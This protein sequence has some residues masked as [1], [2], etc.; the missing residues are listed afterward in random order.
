MW[1]EFRQ[2]CSLSMADDFRVLSTAR[3]TRVCLRVE[4]LQN[5]PRPATVRPARFARPEFRPRLQL[6][7]S[8]SARPERPNCASKIS[9]PRSASFLP[10]F[11]S[12]NSFVILP[13]GIPL[14]C[15][16]RSS[17]R[18]SR[19]EILPPAQ[20]DLSPLVASSPLLFSRRL[21]AA[22]PKFYFD[23][24]GLTCFIIL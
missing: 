9:F 4:V 24:I 13:R 14:R 11:S 6:W 5:S 12:S 19:T 23:K 3:H 16:T 22:L 8:S 2:P 1:P 17:A 21:T 7:S 10:R 15:L 18:K 20:L